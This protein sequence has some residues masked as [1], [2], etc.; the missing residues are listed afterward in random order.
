MT[1]E[2]KKV[3]NRQNAQASTG[4]RSQAGKARAAANARRHG[5]AIP[6]WFDRRYSA[7][8]ERV[9]R[10]NASSFPNP[11]PQLLA[12]AR[13]LA[14]A[15]LDFVRACEVRRT[16]LQPVIDSEAGYWPRKRKNMP[17]VATAVIRKRS[18]R[19]L[20]I[21]H[22]RPT[23][24]KVQLVLSDSAKQL[25]GIERHERRALGRLNRAIQDFDTVC[26]LEAISNKQSD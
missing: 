19:L 7:E 12:H 14:Q 21:C 16:I 23:V 17:R 11:R 8:V 25:N 6:P 4:P 2:M 5:L 1:S 15:Q 24:E 22:A 18:Q 20:R 13:R 9:A 26:I 10:Q 3:A